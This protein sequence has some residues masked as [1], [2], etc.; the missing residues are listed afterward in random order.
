MINPSVSIVKKK[1]WRY[2][3]SVKTFTTRDFELLVNQ[4][5]RVKVTSSRFKNKDGKYEWGI[6]LTSLKKKWD[7]LVT[8]LWLPVGEPNVLFFT[9]KNIIKKYGENEVGAGGMTKVLKKN[10]T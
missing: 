6:T 2:G 3:Y 1:L 5:I 10:V 7:I 8:V 9:R 4:K